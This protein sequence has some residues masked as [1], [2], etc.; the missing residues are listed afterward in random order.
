M[1]NG[2]FYSNSE[3]LEEAKI[4]ANTPG[5]STYT[6]AAQLDMPQATVWYHVTRRLPGLDISLFTQVQA[7]LRKNYK[8][9]GR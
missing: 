8:G 6:V 5:A 2:Y 3:V 7:I 1:R 9:G 4:L